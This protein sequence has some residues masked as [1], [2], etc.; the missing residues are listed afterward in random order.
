MHKTELIES[1]CGLTGQSK[2][3]TGQFLDALIKPI[4][5]AARHGEDVVLVGFGSFKVRKRKARVGRNTATGEEIGIPARRTLAFAPPKAM[6]E[7][8]NQRQ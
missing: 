8:L 6:V 4:H 3:A 2:T 5:K 1:I 7:K